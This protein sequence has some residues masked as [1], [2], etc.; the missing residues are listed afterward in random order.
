MKGNNLKIMNVTILVHGV[1][2]YVK[3]CKIL[4]HFLKYQIAR[5]PQMHF[6]MY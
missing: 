2:I 6:G 5:V 1:A 3:E 4:L